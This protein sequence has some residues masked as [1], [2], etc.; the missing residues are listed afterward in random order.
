MLIEYTTIVNKI[1][2]DIRSA[3]GFTEE[4]PV[5]S[6][7]YPDEEESDKFAVIQRFSDIDI[8]GLT[9]TDENAN[10]QFAIE[11]SFK[12]KDIVS[13]D[14]EQIRLAAQ[15]RAL[16]T[17]NPHYATLGN[18]EF[19]GDQPTVRGIMAPEPVQDSKRFVVGMVFAVRSAIRR[20]LV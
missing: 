12:I 10:W 5:Y 8:D 16:L 4:N 7:V 11:G 13:I 15:L 3:W 19:A 6:T 2:E 9:I 18:G 17:E 1:E 20:G 14:T